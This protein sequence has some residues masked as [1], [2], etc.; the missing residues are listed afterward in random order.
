MT[1]REEL[2]LISFEEIED[3]DIGSLDIDGARDL[4][5]DLTYTLNY[6]S[7]SYYN[8]DNPEISDYQYDRM[9]RCLIGLEDKYPDL[10]A[11]IHLVSGL[12]VGPLKNLT[13][14]G[15]KDPCSA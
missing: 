5:G 15:T 4:V 8:K 6:H 2:K 14:I 7:D 12:V 9:M 3:I 11:Q 13:S 10:K 1:N